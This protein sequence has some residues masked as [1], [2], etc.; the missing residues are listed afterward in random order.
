MENK[1][2]IYKRMPLDM[3]IVLIWVISASIV[4]L[5]YSD[6][7]YMPILGIPAVLF[8]P[9]YVLA[10][11]LFPK[12]DDLYDIERIA[13]GLALSITVIPIL[14]ILLNFT[15]GI[16][17]V[18]MVIAL[19]AWDTIMVLATTYRRNKLPTNERFSVSFHKTYENIVNGLNPKNKKDGILTGILIFMIILF[20]GVAYFAITL[21]KTG[22]KF[23]E[24]YVINNSDKADNYLVNLEVDSTYSYLVGIIN[25]EY[26]PTNYTV[27]IVLDKNVLTS[28]S[29]ILDHDE[30]WKDDITFVPNIEGTD[31]ML[32]F[33]LFK[34]NNFVEPYR[35]LYMWVNST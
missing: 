14:G 11:A 18:P 3:S 28:N 8:I 5:K 6:N 1:L 10:T 31:I 23:T 35:R 15:Y 12:K 32:E 17:L 4:V 19:C 13:L 26:A 34:D 2:S 9:G 21:S 27:E 16:E 7:I 33:W 30:E 20:I 24:F 25:H 29:V 22:E